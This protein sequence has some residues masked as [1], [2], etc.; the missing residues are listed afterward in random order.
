MDPILI[1]CD[2]LIINPTQIKFITRNEIFFIGAT[3]PL[4]ISPNLYAQIAKA[5]TAPGE[6]LKAE[7]ERLK[8]HISLMP[9][10]EEFLKAQSRFNEFQ[11]TIKN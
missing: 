4:K 3:H 2:T 11:D 10:G 6:D 8:L 1:V 7:N 9:G 5:L